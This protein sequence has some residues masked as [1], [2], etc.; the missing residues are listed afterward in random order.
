MEERNAGCGVSGPRQLPA[1]EEVQL[2]S[3]PGRAAEDWRNAPLFDLHEPET[4][5]TLYQPGKVVS[6]I[7]GEIVTA[8]DL[9]LRGGA[10][11]LPDGVLPAAPQ[12]RPVWGRRASR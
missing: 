12:P 2:R 4:V 7:V 6:R 1:W 5:K 8:V 3:V 9:P 10:M 11:A